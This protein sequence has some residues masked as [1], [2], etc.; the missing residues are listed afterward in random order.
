M[1]DLA[2]Q[3]AM[4]V[5]T[6]NRRFRQETGVTPTQWLGRRRLDRARRPPARATNRSTA[7]PPTQASAP[8]RRRAGTRGTCSGC[9]RGRTAT[10]P[11]AARRAAGVRAGGLG[12][13][14][15]PRIRPGRT[16]RG[17]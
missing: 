14:G 6:V 15:R 4:S 5:P 1:E 13:P 9:H 16:G 12:R 11:T 8:G 3:A 10:P 17:S 2:R 7:S